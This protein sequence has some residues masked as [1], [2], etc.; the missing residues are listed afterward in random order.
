MKPVVKLGMCVVILLALFACKNCHGSTGEGKREAGVVA[1]DIRWSQLSK[2]YGFTSTE[3]RRRAAYNRESLAKAITEGIDSSGNTLNY[4]MPRYKLPTS[5][6]AALL[7]YLQHLENELP[8]DAD[9]SAN[10]HECSS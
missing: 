6:L 3:G 7:D 1:Q 9:S 4:S 2:P 5:A 8:G 10:P